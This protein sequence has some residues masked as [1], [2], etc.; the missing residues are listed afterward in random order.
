[1]SNPAVGAK[2]VAAVVMG[3]VGVSAYA[4][5]SHDGRG[6]A[7]P[8]DPAPIVDAPPSTTRQIETTASAVPAKPAQPAPP[9]P[10][11]TR[12]RVRSRGS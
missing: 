11:P 5:V 8:V 4:G 1:M 9:D 12:A 2:C 6:E 10:V 7:P 3:V